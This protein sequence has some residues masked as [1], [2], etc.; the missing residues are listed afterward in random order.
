MKLF[1]V[2]YFMESN[3]LSQAL[4][5]YSSGSNLEY[6]LH[7]IHRQRQ[8]VPLWTGLGSTN[9]IDMAL[10]YQSGGTQE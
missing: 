7:S 5:Y 4:A 9:L 1:G 8:K 2:F 10:E 6:W 3:F